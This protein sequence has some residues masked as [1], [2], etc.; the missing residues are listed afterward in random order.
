MA[1]AGARALGGALRI[2]SAA[3][4][5]TSVALLLPQAAARP[6]IPGDAPGD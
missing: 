6:P 2:E 5:G 1:S 4:A 3:G